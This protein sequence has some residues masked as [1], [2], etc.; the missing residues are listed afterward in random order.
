MK[1]RLILWLL[2]NFQLLAIT[3]CY[4]HRPM[5]YKPDIVLKKDGQ[6]CISI[7]RSEVSFFNKNKQFDI[8]TTEIF[9]EGVGQLR[10]KDYF[11][12]LN[13]GSPKKYYVQIGECLNFDYPFQNNIIYSI[14][15]ESTIRGNDESKKMTQK[16]W[17]R[18]FRIKKDTD[19]TVKLLLDLNA[20]E[21][22]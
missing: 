11:D 1:Q 21:D 6:P 20:R 3:G 16:T 12:P 7:P 18:E 22:K 9:Q 5:V 2:I 8:I 19:G 17:A 10:V 14:N 13:F 4:F 15:F